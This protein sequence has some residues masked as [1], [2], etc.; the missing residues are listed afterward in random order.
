MRAANGL[1]LLNPFGWSLTALVRVG[2]K[3][4]GLRAM[5]CRKRFKPG[6]CVILFLCGRAKLLHIR[7]GRRSL[8]RG[9]LGGGLLTNVLRL[10][11]PV[12]RSL[13][14]LVRVSDKFF[15]LRAVFC[16]KRFKPGNRIIL[17]L[18]R[19]AQAFDR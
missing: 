16:R 6:N 12:G 19:C 13:T 15:W 3:F 11:H 1:R 14:A 5:F 2:D 9:L 17:L 10:L 4:F 7:L 18:S 8:R